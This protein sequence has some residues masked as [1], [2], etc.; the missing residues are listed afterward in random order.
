LGE[1][2]PKLRVNSLETIPIS[3]YLVQTIDGM[4]IQL[5]RPI[6]FLDLETTGLNL[7]TDRVVEIAMIRVNIDGTRTL[8]RKLI[9]PERNIP[10][11]S[12]AIHGIT[13]EMVK[14]APVFKQVANEVKQF[15]DGADLG[16]YNSN[17]F[18]WP[19]LAEEFL[20]SG[21][22]FDIAGRKLLDV[23]KIYHLMEPRNLSAAYKF[24]CHKE[25]ENAHTASSDVDATWEVFEA[26]L[27]KYPQLGNTVDSVMKLIGEDEI[28]D[29]ARRMVK[30]KGREYF[31]FGKHKGKA[32]EDVFKAEPSY[33]DWMMKSEFPL[34]T[35][36]KLT[37]IFNRT[38]LKNK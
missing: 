18:D 12:S 33:Y 27:Q 19:M 1:N 26:Q 21:L 25:L 5:Q 34:H 29:F 7:T 6:V 9:N 10:A 32:V 38:M 24:Y 2:S 31:N 37:E 16:G 14:D 4:N 30:E 20:R 15:M 3:P 23:Q 28:V 36:L 8:K 11:E 35:K 22:E 13:N 17:K